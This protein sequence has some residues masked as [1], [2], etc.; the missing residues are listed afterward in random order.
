MPFTQSRKIH[1]LLAEIFGDND[2]A[3]LAAARINQIFAV[4]R[5]GE[6]VKFEVVGIFE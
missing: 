1:A 3:H 5:E 6:V 4:G 2:F